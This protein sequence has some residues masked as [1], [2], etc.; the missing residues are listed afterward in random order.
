MADS[1]NAIIW[2]CDQLSTTFY[3]KL[4]R[5]FHSKYVTSYAAIEQPEG[6][7]SVKS[8]MLRISDSRL[9]AHIQSGF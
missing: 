9:A 5:D 8:A 4:K 6:S 7:I 2:L 1:L 3:S